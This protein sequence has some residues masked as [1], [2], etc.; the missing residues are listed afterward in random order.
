MPR[1]EETILI[2]RP[3]DDVFEFVAAPENDHRWF[4]T[5][6][7]RIREPDEAIRVGSK[8]HAV[9]KFLGR[10]IRSTFEVTE[11]EP[12]RRSSIRMDRPFAASGS[13]VLEPAD[14]GTRFRWIMDADPGLGRLY[15]GRIADP[16]VA[17]IFRRGVRGDLRRLKRVLEESRADAGS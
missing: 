13:Y 15:L 4:G 9:D 16:L 8:V 6:V 5:A 10:R 12:P 2:E 7:E 3:P 11:H 14:G 1:V 17:G